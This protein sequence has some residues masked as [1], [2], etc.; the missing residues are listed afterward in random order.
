ME[1]INQ[2]DALTTALFSGR[3]IL[4]KS[5]SRE[6]KNRFSQ[7]FTAYKVLGKTSWI[8]RDIYSQFFNYCPIYLHQFGLLLQSTT[9]W[10]AFKQQKFMY[11]SSGG[12]KSKIRV[13]ALLDSGVTD[14]QIFAVTSHG[15]K[16]V[17][18]PLLIR[19]QIPSIKAVFS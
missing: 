17:L 2:I 13:P 9:V 6:Y 5:R 4:A 15:G 10:G 16:E 3:S 12:R 14:C 8:L 19:A 7:F 1:N 11:H 18:C